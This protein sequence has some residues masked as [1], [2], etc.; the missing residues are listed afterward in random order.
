MTSHMTMETGLLRPFPLRLRT[1]LRS[2]SHPL[3]LNLHGSSHLIIPVQ[4]FQTPAAR[5]NIRPPSLPNLPH[6]K[7][8]LR[9]R[10]GLLLRRS[11]TR[12]IRLLHPFTLTPH[13]QALALLNPLGATMSRQNQQCPPAITVSR[14]SPSSRQSRQSLRQSLT[15]ASIPPFQFTQPPH[16][17]TRPRL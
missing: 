5:G 10:H 1:R 2:M 15:P 12:H 17:R 7:S 11:L 9:I 13:P 14:R 4:R 8:Q 6:G 3:P 16:R